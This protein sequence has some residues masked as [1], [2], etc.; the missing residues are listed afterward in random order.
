MFHCIIQFCRN[1]YYLSLNLDIACLHSVASLAVL[2][3]KT[4]NLTEFK[5][6]W[7]W[8]LLFGGKFIF[9]GI[10]RNFEIFEIFGKIPDFILEFYSMTGIVRTFLVVKFQ[11]MIPNFGLVSEATKISLVCRPTLNWQIMHWIVSQLQ[12]QMLLLNEMF[13]CD[14]RMSITTC[15]VKISFATCDVFV[16]KWNK[17]TFDSISVIITIIL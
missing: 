11:T 10:W 7:R 13:T 17:V 15:D 2:P 1:F 8:K 14:I 5:S 12:S 9:G 3:P 4:G 6:Q 16:N